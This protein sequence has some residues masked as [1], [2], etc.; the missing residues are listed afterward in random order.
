VPIAPS[1]LSSSKLL[2]YNFIHLFYF[3]YLSPSTF[4]WTVTSNIR[5]L[6]SSLILKDQVLETFKTTG[7][8][9]VFSITFVFSDV[10][11]KT[12]D[13]GLKGA[14]CN[15]AECIQSQFQVSTKRPVSKEVCRLLLN[16]R[17]TAINSDVLCN[18]HTMLTLLKH[19][20]SHVTAVNRR[21][22]RIFQNISSVVRDL[23][24]NTFAATLHN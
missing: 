20:A 18:I 4:L 9:N 24:F 21:S 23:L 15:T 6:C 1:V 10:K 7:K 22:A 14:C 19:N 11:Q 12:K 2:L 17:L 8:L 5:S 16:Q 3:L 13:S